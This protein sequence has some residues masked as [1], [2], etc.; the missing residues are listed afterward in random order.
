[1]KKLAENILMLLG[2]VFIKDSI[3]VSGFKISLMLS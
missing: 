2:S 3:C 1:L